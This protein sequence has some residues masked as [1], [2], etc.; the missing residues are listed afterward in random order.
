M[1]QQNSQQQTHSFY[2]YYPK[3]TWVT[4]GELYSLKQT[5]FQKIIKDCVGPQFPSV[6]GKS[7]HNIVLILT[8]TIFHVSNCT[9]SCSSEKA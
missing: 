3:I 2:S 6:D 5:L 8:T 9:C 4:E 1:Q 7:H